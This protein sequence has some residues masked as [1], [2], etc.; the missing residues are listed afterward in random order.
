MVDG[1]ASMYLGSPRMAEEVIGEKATLEEMGGARMHCE[2]SGC[3]DL[4]VQDDKAAIEAAKGYLSYFGQ[5]FK[6]QPP[7]VEA[8]PPG[9]RGSLASIVP[10]D[11]GQAFDMYAL[12]AGLIDEA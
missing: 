4:L 1:N 9:Y 5:S 7:R 11:E 2:V 3:G 8:R 6:D 10:A 12:I